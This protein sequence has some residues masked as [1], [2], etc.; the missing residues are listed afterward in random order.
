MISPQSGG[1]ICT[2][3]PESAPNL[4]VR[5]AVTIAFTSTTQPAYKSYNNKQQCHNVEKCGAGSTFLTY[6]NGST[7]NNI[8]KNFGELIIIIVIPSVSKLGCK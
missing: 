3:N 1:T 4:F 2:A 6:S 8:T 7:N 5:W